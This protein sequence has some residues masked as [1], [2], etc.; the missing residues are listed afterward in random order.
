MDEY[1]EQW[2]DMKLDYEKN[3]ETGNFEHNMTSCYFP[4]AGLAPCGYGLTV[5]DHVNNVILDMQGY[6]TFDSLYVAGVSLDI[7]K[8]DEGNYECRMDDSQ[9]LCFKE[10]LEDDRILGIE[11]INK[12]CDGLDVIPLPTKDLTELV[13]IL[14]DFDN[15]VKRKW[16][17][18]ALDTRPFTIERFGE[19]DPNELRRMRER[20]LD[21]GFILTD[22][23]EE[24]WAEV[25]KECGEDYDDDFNYGY[26]EG[27]DEPRDVEQDLIEMAEEVLNGPEEK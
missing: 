6:T 7:H 4:S 12:N 13:K 1:L 27:D 15:A 11:S 22:D 21:L 2:I 14:G 5:V 10:F 19:Y 25:I 20:V 8:N 17:N 9:F 3:V 23:E 26:E 18:F 16:F 24:T